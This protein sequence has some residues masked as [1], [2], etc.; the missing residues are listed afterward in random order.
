MNW[1]TS[2][3]DN[4]LSLC[5]K[6]LKICPVLSIDWL[7]IHC[8]TYFVLPSNVRLRINWFVVRYHDN[9][10]AYNLQA[11]HNGV[12]RAKDCYKP[13]NGIY[14]I[15]NIH[16]LLMDFFFVYEFSTAC[17][18]SC[19]CKIDFVQ[20]SLK[21]LLNISVWLFQLTVHSWFKS[22]KRAWLREVVEIIYWYKMTR[23]TCLQKLT[24]MVL[25]IVSVLLNEVCSV[26]K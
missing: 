8:C 12:Y 16:P 10:N 17:R 6:T 11:C 23:I 19:D 5:I 9:H 15:K 14:L 3:W 13:G 18:L 7:L 4:I 25:V 20:W 22:F 26:S 2:Y 24:K 21:G 1:L